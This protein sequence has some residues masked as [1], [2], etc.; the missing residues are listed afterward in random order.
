MK[1]IVAISAAL[2]LS[3][4]AVTPAQAVSAPKPG[5]A[6]TQSGA[7][8]ALKTTTSICQLSG[9]KL[10]WS[11]ALKASKSSLTMAD[12]W[13][14]ATE[15]SM[16]MTGAF[17]TFVNSTSKP[18]K[19]VAAYASTSISKFSQLHEVVMKDMA[20]TMQEKAGGFTVPAKGKYQLRP[21]SDHTMIMGLVKDILPGSILNVTYVTSTGARFSQNFLAKFYV[22][23]AET[24]D[25]TPANTSAVSFTGTGTGQA[26]GVTIVNPVL[27]K[28]DSMMAVKDASGVTYKTGGFMVID[29]KGKAD[30]T[31]VGGTS[32]YGT[33]A[34]VD[35]T[36]GSNQ[37]SVMPNGL[38]VKAGTS[39]KLRM[40]GYHIT[41]TGVT[42]DVPAG[43][44]VNVVLKFSDGSTLN[45]VMKFMIIPSTDPTYGFATN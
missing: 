39:Q 31:L 11:Q 3:L 9:S 10:T 17:G 7:V 30:V 37:W 22:G 34:S 42:M 35:Q 18:V 21:G 27:R 41:I 5:S 14:K 36:I 44:K 1:K 38:T 40:K 19:I 16:G 4:V 26:A 32:D 15:K 2:L 29:N 24:Y 23:G 8:I 33:F 6:C 12:S 43:K 25:E 13:V 28:P 20:M 45:T